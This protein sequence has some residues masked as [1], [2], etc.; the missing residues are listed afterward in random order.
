[1]YEETIFDFDGKRY[2]LTRNLVTGDV[3]LDVFLVDGRVAEVNLD[4]IDAELRGEMNWAW[5][6]KWGSNLPCDDGQGREPE[7]TDLDGGADL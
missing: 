2:M 1:M 5:E 4:T 7:W 3:T 6:Q